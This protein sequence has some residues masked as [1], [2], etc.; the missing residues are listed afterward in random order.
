[1]EVL[2]EE[3]WEGRRVQKVVDEQGVRKDG[4]K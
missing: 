1:M 3:V 4:M 2:E